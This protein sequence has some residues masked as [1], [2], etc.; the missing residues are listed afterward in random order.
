MVDRFWCAIIA[1]NILAIAGI[2]YLLR[3][4]FSHRIGFRRRTIELPKVLVILLYWL[5]FFVP[6]M[7]IAVVLAT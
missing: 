3:H 2:A 4:T 6:A 5:L 1:S 7:L